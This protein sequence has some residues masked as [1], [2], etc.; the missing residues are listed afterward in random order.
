M[1]FCGFYGTMAA[2]IL[3]IAGSAKVYVWI[4]FIRVSCQ[5]LIRD[6][7]KERL[8]E[9]VDMGEKSAPRSILRDQTAW[10]TLKH[11]FF[12]TLAF[13]LVAHGYRYFNA[14]FNHDSLS[15][16]YESNMRSPIAVGRFM[17]PL[18]WL[19]RGKI[20]LPAFGGFLS[21]VYLCGA[22]YLLVTILG[23][24]KKSQIA[25][26]CG[27]MVVNSSMV[28]LN[29]T[30]VHDADAYCLSL[31]LVMLGVW[32]SLHWKHG[33]IWA[34]PLYLCSLGLYQAYIGAAVYVF[35]ILALVELLRGEKVKTVYRE[36]IL[37][38]LSIA[39]AMVLLFVCSKAAQAITHIGG[40]QTYQ[41][42]TN[43]PAVTVRSTLERLANCL[44]SE[45]T[46]LLYPP[47][48]SKHFIIIANVLMLAL[49]VICGIG[50]L[51]RR[52]LRA[53]S[54]WGIVGVIAAMPFGMSVITLIGNMYH[55]LTMFPLNLSYL[56]VLVLVQ[57]YGQVHEAK[58]AAKRCSWLWAVLAGVLIFE[59]CLYAN[60][61]YLKKEL[62]DTATLSTF[63]RIIDRMEQTDG[64]VL[65]QT[66][67]AFVGQMQDSVLSNP[68]PGF[69]IRGHGN[70][71]NFDVTYYENI[72]TYLT[73]YL[74]YPVTCVGT[75]QA[76]ALG[77][78]P[79]VLQMPAFPAVGSIKMVDDV[80]VVKLS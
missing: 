79:E 73:Y 67:V 3:C 25:L 39:A 6:T 52:G 69:E 28:S 47:G 29:A 65:G 72:V 2:Y 11:V 17:R 62:E 19:L 9:M 64:F 55:W 37:S 15:C 54:V 48:N 32:S 46:W 20:A 49:A 80:L 74:G 75:R 10:E 41:S 59:N 71:T 38:F 43:V 31:L 61:I 70:D 14:N 45:G 51:R 57:E 66:Q 58:P 36:T 23:I 40:A 18:Y 12:W 77:E 63:T 68:R 50:T 16:I 42:V 21:L 13:G 78:T 60:E 4:I 35:L 1:K 22:T 8:T 30:F 27:L 24:Q 5:A 53:A 76:A 34:V 44:L 7:E 33:R 26:A 56:L